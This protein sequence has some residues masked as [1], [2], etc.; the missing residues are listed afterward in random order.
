MIMKTESYS[1]RSLVVGA[2]LLISALVS[3]PVFAVDDGA[4]SYWKARAGTQVFSFQ[5]L[6]LNMQASG[7]L[8][9]DPGLYLYPNSDTEANVMIASWATHFTLFNSP[10]T[11]SVNLV[12]GSVDATVDTGAIPPE[13]LPPGVEPGGFFSQSTSGFGDPSMQ[14]TMNLFGTP[15]LIS[16]VDLLNYE[17]TWT[18]DAAVMLGVP[19][20]QY[21]SD[22]VVNMGLNRVYGRVAFPFKVHFGPFTPGYM[23][24][25]EFTPSVWLFAENDDFLGQE[26][27]NDPMVQFEGHLTHDFTPTF[28][29]SLDLL[30]RSGFQSKI[31]G[32]EAGDELNIGNIGFTFNFQVTDNVALRAGYSSNVFGDNEV[33]NSVIRI[34]L[35]YGWHTLMENA[36]KLQHH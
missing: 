28:F 1:A 2:A 22:Q 9:F 29:A 7:A 31:D 14:L 35:V 16:T 34:Q 32:V 33:K 13:F 20:G 25:L 36:K 23:T 12:G 27:D 5:Y 10:S 26:L 11:F 4:R 15:P 30:Y 6:N 17:P 3:G 19:I 21:E 18:L 24:S 8:Q